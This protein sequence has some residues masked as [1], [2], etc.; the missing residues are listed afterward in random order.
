MA[1]SL[2]SWTA[3]FYYDLWPSFRVIPH[4]P[5]PGFS[6][7]AS[8]LLSRS[9]VV[10]TSRSLWCQRSNVLIVFQRTLLWIWHLHCSTWRPPSKLNGLSRCLMICMSFVSEIS[11]PL[12]HCPRFS[13]A[14]FLWRLYKN[15]MFIS[16][17]TYIVLSFGTLFTG[18]PSII[19]CKNQ[20]RVLDFNIQFCF[21]CPFKCSPDRE[22]HGL[23]KLRPGHV[24]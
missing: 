5:L 14:P 9:S 6:Y 18:I 21:P 11:Q 20:G 19:R 12:S 3:S 13:S 7:C 22:L 8:L 10:Q 16:G 1:L 23:Q 4:H 2:S 15:G 24:H 17:C